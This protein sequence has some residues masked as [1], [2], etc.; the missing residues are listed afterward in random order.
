M[1]STTLNFKIVFSTY[2]EREA[3]YTYAPSTEDWEKVNKVCKLLSVINL[4]TH[5]IFGSEY[6][7]SNLFLAEIWKVKLVLDIV[8]GENDLFMREMEV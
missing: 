4:A 7:T 6:P 1:L 5:V 2:A 8:A 3:H